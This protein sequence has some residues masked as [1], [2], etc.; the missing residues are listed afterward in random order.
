M[1]EELLLSQKSY[2]AHPGVYLMKDGAGAVL[3]VGKALNLKARLRGYFS[4]ADERYQIQFLMK[5]VTAIETI[6]CS[7]E[8]QALVLERDLIGRYKPRYNIRLKDDKAYLCVRIDT[9]NKWPRL[10]LV[11]KVYDDGATYFGP[12]TNSYELKELLEVMKEVIP[13]R[14][15]TDTVLYNRQRPCLEYQIKHCIAPCCLAVDPDHYATMVKQAI[16][17]LKGKT[18]KVRESL[19]QAMLEASENLKFEEAGFIRDRLNVLEKYSEGQRAVFSFGDERDVFALYREGE[20][21]VVTVLRAV[22]GRISDTINFSLEDV[23]LDDQ[24]ILESS[25]Q[26]FYEGGRA[27]PAEILLPIPLFNQHM[28]VEDLKKKKKENVE[29]LVPE[30]G[31]KFH[32]LRLAALNAEQTFAASFNRDEI[33]QNI[34]VKLSLILKLRQVPRRIECVDISNFQGSDIVGAVVVFFDGEPL[35]SGYLKFRFRESTTPD[36]FGSIYEVVKRRLAKGM[37]TGELPDLLIID[38]GRGQLSAALKARDELRLDLDVAAIAKERSESGIGADQITKKPERLFTEWSENSI[39]LAATAD[40]TH[41]LQRIRDEVHRFVITF[42]RSTRKK[43]VA[44]S[45]LDNILGLGPE[46]KARLMKEFGSVKAIGNAK[47][48][49]V[50]KAGRMPLPLAEKVIRAIKHEAA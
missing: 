21:V 7:S 25:V 15:C 10:Q 8:E 9:E 49:S 28:I 2:P 1:A 5:K 4:G 40:V 35:K 14:T 33:Y 26:Q 3:Y 38:G 13:L 31:S 11:R 47:P 32:L 50:A 6:V 18:K 41:L 46:R 37:E 43:R 20:Q 22:Q 16:D 29:I 12:Y 48:E 24:S 17:I 23:I 36:D 39:P 19:E 45:V 27:I 34:A 30:R 42:H 44:A